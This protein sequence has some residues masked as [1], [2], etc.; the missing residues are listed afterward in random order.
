MSIGEFVRYSEVL[1]R[2]TVDFAR[3]VTDD[4][5]DFTPE[6]PRTSGRM[7]APH[8]IGRRLRGVLQATAAR[9]CL[10]GVYEAALTTGKVEWTRKPDHYAGPLTRETLL[11]ALEGKQRNLIATLATV[12]VDAPIDWNGTPFTFALFTWKFVQHEAI[13]HGHWSIYASVA[14]FDTPLSWRTSW[15][16]EYPG[17]VPLT[18]TGVSAASAADAGDICG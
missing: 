15:A 10:R 5:W 8:W 4:K 9:R 16:S 6:P 2:L 13:H 12:D 18:Q 17:H 11:A 3:A 7:P 14:R 1:Y